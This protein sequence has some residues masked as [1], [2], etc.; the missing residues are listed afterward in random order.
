MIV[1]EAGLTEKVCVTLAAALK[2]PLPACAAVM[3]QVPAPV[4]VTL[5]PET[6]QTAGVVEEKA[7]GRPEEAVAAIPIGETP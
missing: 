7:T 2:L 3:E 1:C 6:V 4:I 5:A